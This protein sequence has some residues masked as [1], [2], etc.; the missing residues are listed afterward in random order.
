MDKWGDRKPDAAL[1]KQ[2]NEDHQ[3]EINQVNLNRDG[4]LALVLAFLVAPG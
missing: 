1:F 4:L 2:R 3:D